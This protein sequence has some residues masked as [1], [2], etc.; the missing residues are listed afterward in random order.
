MARVRILHGMVHNHGFRSRQVSRQT[1]VS[2]RIVEHTMFGEPRSGSCVELVDV[3]GMVGMQRRLQVL[4]KQRVIAE[5]RGRFIKRRGEHV[6]RH[7]LAKDTETPDLT[8]Q[9]IAE[10]GVQDP[11][12]AC[13]KEKRTDVVVEPLHCLRS[14]VF[15]QMPCVAGES[16]Q[17][18]RRVRSVSQ[19]KASKLK[20]DGPAF[21]STLQSVDLVGGQ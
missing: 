19:S 2:D 15:G 18:F 20:A 9:V 7:E 1:G 3:L 13:R 16:I 8:S 10:V 21:G 12:N 11:H 17:V 5:H 4:T 6:R 14:Q